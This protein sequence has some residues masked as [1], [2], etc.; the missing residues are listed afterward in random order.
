VASGTHTNRDL[1]PWFSEEE[2]TACASCREDS[3]VTLPDAT[4]SFCLACGAITVDGTRIDP[5]R[6]AGEPGKH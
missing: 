5:V 1:L 3:C 6:E 4:A 2:R